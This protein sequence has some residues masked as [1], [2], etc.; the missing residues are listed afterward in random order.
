MNTQKTNLKNCTAIKTNGTNSIT[1]YNM[2]NS[3]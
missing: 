3:L 2:T 1:M